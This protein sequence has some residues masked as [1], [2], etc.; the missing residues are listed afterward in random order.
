MLSTDFS[1][2]EGELGLYN[3]YIHDIS[4]SCIMLIKGPTLK[5]RRLVVTKKRASA[6]DELYGN[7]SDFTSKEV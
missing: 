3:I 1:V 2:H 7:E 6:I 5:L 4:N